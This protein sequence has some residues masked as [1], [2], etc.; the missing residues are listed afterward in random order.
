MAVDLSCPNATKRGPISLMPALRG[1][2]SLGNRS[3]ITRGLRSFMYMNGTV[4]K[5]HD[6]ECLLKQED[7]QQ[8][9]KR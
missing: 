5:E 3:A 8:H 6:Q 4:D 9:N 1:R 2:C 7:L